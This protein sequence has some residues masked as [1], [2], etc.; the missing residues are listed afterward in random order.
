MVMSTAVFPKLLDTK[1]MANT[2][3]FK[4]EIFNS[5][6][7][8][9]HKAVTLPPYNLPP[10][11]PKYSG[12]GY[13][14]DSSNYHE[15]GFDAYITG[16][17]FIAMSN[18]LGLL[19]NTGDKIK[20]GRVLPDRDHV[21]HITFPAEWKTADIVHLFSSFGYVFVPWIDDTSAFVSLKEKDMAHQ[22]ME[23]LKS[24][25]SCR[26]QTFKDFTIA[27]D[28]LNTL[29]NCGITPTL[30]K[31]VLGS[32]GSIEKKRTRSPEQAAVKRHKSVSDDAAVVKVD[33][34]KTFEEPDLLSKLLS[35]DTSLL[36]MMLQL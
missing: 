26:I 32:N 10:V 18:R 22:V 27:K 12:S 35:R 21:F 1:L 7:E 33:S 9:L 28:S 30:E 8:E 16:L 25:S 13:K 15:A 19:C 31:T 36:V 24:S 5:S 20:N 11:P 4:Q 14:A 34:K 23:V 2:I 3:P 17:C 29:Q 6:L